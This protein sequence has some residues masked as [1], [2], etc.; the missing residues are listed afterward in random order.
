MTSLREEIIDIIK[1]Y[2]MFYQAEILGDVL[3]SKIENFIDEYMET[4][5][6]NDNGRH[7][8]DKTYSS[9]ALIDLKEKIKDD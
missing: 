7:L 8:S 9:I 6:N 4:Y 2:V 1:P 5:V 3:I